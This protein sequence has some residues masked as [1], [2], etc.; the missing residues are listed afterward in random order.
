MNTRIMR[1]AVSAAALSAV[2][3][4]PAVAHAADAPVKPSPCCTQQTERLL[5]AESA[6]ERLKSVNE[7]AAVKAAVKKSNQADGDWQD[8]R[9]A[10]EVALDNGV[11]GSELAALKAQEKRAGDALDKAY[12]EERAAREKAAKPHAAAKKERDNAERALKACLKRH[13]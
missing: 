13:R 2:L 8:A 6:A 4:A 10:V 9:L 1:A 5:K 11:G 12:A 7:D 3:F